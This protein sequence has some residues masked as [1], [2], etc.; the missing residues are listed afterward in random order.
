[1]QPGNDSVQDHRKRLQLGYAE[2][3]GTRQGWRPWPRAWDLTAALRRR[4]R[5]QAAPEGMQGHPRSA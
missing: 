2:P 1:M 5:L 3:G 4:H